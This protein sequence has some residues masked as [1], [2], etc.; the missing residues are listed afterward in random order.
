MKSF[1]QK[2]AKTTKGDGVAD[3]GPVGRRVHLCVACSCSVGRN[4]GSGHGVGRNRSCGLRHSA[5]KAADVIR[6]SVADLGSRSVGRRT[7]ETS[8]PFGKTG[9]RSPRLQG[10]KTGFVSPPTYHRPPPPPQKN[11][12]GRFSS[13]PPRVASSIG[14]RRLLPPTT[15]HLPLPPLTGRGTRC[16]RALCCSS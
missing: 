2:A 11:G 6:S 1:E 16:L 14:L 8:Y 15:Y 7:G 10:G 12:A 9:V 3:L 4:S 13:D 5:V